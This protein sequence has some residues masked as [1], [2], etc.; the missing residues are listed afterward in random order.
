MVHEVPAP[1]LYVRPYFNRYTE[2]DPTY[3]TVVLV[4]DAGKSHVTRDHEG[5][6]LA[7]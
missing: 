6:G 7:G 4:L 1:G 3:W 2:D 5:H